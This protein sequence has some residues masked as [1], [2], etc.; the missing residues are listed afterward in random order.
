MKTDNTQETRHNYHIYG[1]RKERTGYVT[2]KR[3]SKEKIGTNAILTKCTPALENTVEV[4]LKLDE[5]TDL[6]SNKAVSL[7][8]I[9]AVSGVIFIIVCLFW[10]LLCQEK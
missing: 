6:D 10:R 1:E 2:R 3:Y 8:V 9:L 4:G 5:V 7:T